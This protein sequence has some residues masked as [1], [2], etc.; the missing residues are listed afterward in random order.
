MAK[1]RKIWRGDAVWLVKAVRMKMKTPECVPMCAT[2]LRN[3]FFF[4]RR[5][6]SIAF[7]PILYS[8]PRK[9]LSLNT[10]ARVCVCRTKYSHMW[11]VVYVTI[12]VVILS[13]GCAFILCMCYLL[14]RCWIRYVFSTRRRIMCNWL[15]MKRSFLPQSCRF[16]HTR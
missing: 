4:H 10:I 7:Q 11:I 12:P 1:R 9:Q 5:G 2:E 8:Q 6:V 3:H 13:N 16:S 14:V 15:G